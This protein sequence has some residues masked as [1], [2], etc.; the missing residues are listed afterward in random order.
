M[1]L[2]KNSKP[3]A[4]LQLIF[5]KK[6]KTIRIVIFSLLKKDILFHNTEKMAGYIVIHRF[7]HSRFV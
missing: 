4:R 6:D 7:K 1:I 3:S 5:K 2:F